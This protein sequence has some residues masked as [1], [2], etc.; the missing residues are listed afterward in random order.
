[1]FQSD[2]DPLE[3]LE[4]L[5]VVAMS[6]EQSIDEL[7]ARVQEQAQLMEMMATQVRHLTTA[8]VGL[9]NQNRMLATRLDRWEGTVHD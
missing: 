3:L 9:Q 6:H 8:V 2:F 4:R 5:Q 1:M 7:Q